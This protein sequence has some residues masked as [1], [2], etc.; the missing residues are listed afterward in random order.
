MSSVVADLKFAVRM[1]TRGPGITAILVLTLALGIA[2]STAIFSVVNSVLLK[3]LPYEQPEQLVRVYTEF[4]GKM[5]LRKFAVSVPEY[6]NLARDCKTCAAVA[7]WGNGT[8]SLSGGDRPVRVDAAYATHQLLPMLGVKPMLG[9]T[10]TADED[11]PGDPTVVVL[12]HGVWQRAF[13]GDPDIVGKAIRLD[14]MPV[15]IIGV[16][17]PGFDF[18]GRM[19]AWV[20]ACLDPNNN[21][22]GGHWL[23]MLV[24]L[25]PGASPRA[26]ETEVRGLEAQ[27][28]QKTNPFNHHID[29]ETHPLIAVPLQ[30]DIVGG[31]STALWLLQAAAL[32]V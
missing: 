26:F 16:M 7:A 20:P 18:L 5:E 1:M 14:A 23:R 4:L 19:E 3:P 32:F 25:A 30:D 24:R 17:P 8:A 15:T 11:R 9:R 31:M 10:F 21:R 27:W 29:H 2:A 28:K 13:G 12:G 22:V 6:F